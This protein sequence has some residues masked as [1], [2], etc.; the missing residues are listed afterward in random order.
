MLYH[1]L[2]LSSYLICTKWMK[3]FRN[4]ETAKSN[5]VPQTADPADLEGRV[6][7]KLPIYLLAFFHLSLLISPSPFPFIHRG[8]SPDSKECQQER[9]NGKGEKL[10]TQSISAI[11][12]SG[13]GA[14]I[15]DDACPCILL[16][17]E[18]ASGLWED[19]G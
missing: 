15:C 11:I 19:E 3:S 17:S 18:L 13:L 9:R 2:D 12:S 4:E 16:V 10:H 5:S 7:R 8:S 14:C 6:H 1:H